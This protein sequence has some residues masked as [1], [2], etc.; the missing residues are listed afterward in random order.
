MSRSTLTAN[1]KYTARYC[2]NF[3]TPIKM[4]LSLKPKTFIDSF[5]PFLESTSNFNHFEKKIILIAPSFREL[6]T[7]KDLVRPLSKKH[8][9][10]IL[11]YSHHVKGSQT[12]VK[13]ALEHFH[14]IFSLI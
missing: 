5:F 12:L 10:R 11:F 8:R 13:S 6:Q 1:D 2:Q 4:K 3:S 14:N 7:V 9:F